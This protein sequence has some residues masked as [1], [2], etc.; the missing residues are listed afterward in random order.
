MVRTASFNCL[1]LLAFL[2]FGLARLSAQVPSE[3]RDFSFL[4][5][6]SEG[7]GAFAESGSFNLDIA[8]SGDYAVRGNENVAD[9][10]GVAEVPFSSGQR[11]DLNVFDSDV[12]LL[13]GILEFDSLLSGSFQFSASGLGYQLG[14]FSIL[15]SHYSFEQFLGPLKFQGFDIFSYKHRGFVYP[16]EN[17]PESSYFYDYILG[18]WWF[19]SASVYPWVYVFGSDKLEEGWY[20]FFD[21]SASRHGY[22]VFRRATDSMTVSDAS[23]R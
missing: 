4:F 10:F 18:Q 19:S 22:R 21:Q 2:L 20:F 6:I 1:A 16:V 12:G 7:A 13:S 23:F 8:P 17:T 9:S 11:L 15:Q 3:V 5:T 14:Q